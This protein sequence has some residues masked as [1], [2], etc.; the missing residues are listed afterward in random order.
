MQGNVA[1]GRNT[2]NEVKDLSSV[3]FSR[4]SLKI[5]A[6]SQSRLAR[7]IASHIVSPGG[8]NLTSHIWTERLTA[9]SNV[10]FANMP[11]VRAFAK[12][13]IEELLC[14]AARARKRSIPTKNKPDK[15]R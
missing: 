15:N 14:V 1:H 8:R 6:K 12:L 13:A 11:D 10:Y 4:E 5:R 3:R 2:A 9:R 7:R